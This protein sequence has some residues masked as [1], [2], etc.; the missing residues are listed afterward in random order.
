MN[1]KGMTDDQLRDINIS[2]LSQRQLDELKVELL[3]RIHCTKN[4]NHSRRQCDKNILK[5]D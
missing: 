2:G 1:L 5:K 4:R 3:M